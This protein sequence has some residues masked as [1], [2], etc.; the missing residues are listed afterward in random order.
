MSETFAPPTVDKD[1]LVALKGMLAEA[2][3]Q[4]AE[5]H[6]VFPGLEAARLYSEKI[7]ELLLHHINE[8]AKR[9]G[10]DDLRESVCLAAIGGFGRSELLLHSDLDFCFLTDRE[11][12]ERQVEFIKAFLYPLWDLR[13]DLG[14]CHHS[15]KEALSFLGTDLSKTTALLETRYMWGEK[16]LCEELNER[17]HAKLHKD[18][19]QWF[20]KAL[21]EEARAR[22]TAHGDTVFL[23]EPDLK[24]SRGALRDLHTLLWIAFAN[25]G[26]SSL[27]LLEDNGI[28][29]YS[30]KMR[31]L[32]AWSFLLDLRNSLHLAAN[33]RIDKLTIDRQIDAAKR[34]GMEVTNATLAEETLMRFYYNHA[35]VVD[36][37]CQRLL[38]A[39]M[40]RVSSDE[41][42]RPTAP[43]QQIDRHFLVRGKDIWVEQRD[44][45][46]VVQDP[47]W[48]LR[49]FHIAAHE[50]KNPTDETLRHVEEH[51]RVV[52]DVFRKSPMAR[53][54]FLSVL[55]E[56]GHIAETLR[57][58]N[59]CGLLSA[60]LPEF[61]AVHNLPRIDHYHQFTVDEHLIRSV[62]VAERLQND[63][64]P[65]GMEHVAHVAKS[66]LRLDLLHLAL[67]IHDVGKGEG[68]AHVIRGMHS[69]Q[70][71]A[72]RMDMRPAEQEV[73]RSLVAN[74]QKMS[75]MALRRDIEDPNLAKELAEA[76][77][78]P[79]MLNMLYVHSAC[80][81]RAVSNDSW[82]DWRGRLL[83]DLYE[84]TMLV[85]KGQHETQPRRQ[86][87]NDLRDRI[88]DEVLKLDASP[89][90]DK[91]TLENFITDMPERYLRSVSV[92]DIA[93]HC[94]M[95]TR[96][97]REHRI[98]CHVD[99]FDSAN[100]VQITFVS[101][102]APGLFSDICGALATRG[103]NILS[104]Q[105]YTAMS[106]EAV[107]IFQVKVPPKIAASIQE[108]LQ[109]ISDQL[110]KIMETGER[111]EW[112]TLVRK[113]IGERP[114]SEDRL[115]LRPPRVDINNDTSPTH[116]VVE[117]RAPDQPGLL[118]EITHVFGRHG[119]NI[120]LA[121]IATESYQIVDVFYVTDLETNK[122]QEPARIKALHSELMEVV[123]SR[124][125]PA[126]S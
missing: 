98:A 46:V 85:L 111:P 54:Y 67:L 118:S 25:H 53:W 49:L 95:S 87:R 82:N 109:R 59:R 22:H 88:W 89:Y 123:N 40:R 52:D 17:V 16:S 72:E 29:S 38:D 101:N 75:H 96:L 90:I 74:H 107:D 11:P 117:V 45:P 18:H 33:R 63:D 51:N 23:L 113:Q 42:H 91:P 10:G 73:L 68:R 104:A 97:N 76:V 5:R 120:D 57:A 30:E 64:P 103:I 26:A 3:E 60:Y 24:N 66:I 20:A 100:Y 119:V 80:D 6:R 116:T 44:L 31:L 114:V 70:R 50:G 77:G 79:E 27:D 62:G 43:P 99:D 8:T 84:R 122:L 34:M 55:Q 19:K 1:Y 108:V 102:D 41:E 115:S 4:A 125:R 110:T 69:A 78:R 94:L 13:F 93:R 126:D 112:T 81:L 86:P 32:A 37:V 21:V 83:A 92:T 36:R 61:A 9:F 124:L 7:E 12:T 39:Q 105:I 15:I 58:M 28:I 48:A 47:Y 71:I 14:N 35:N 2:R 56:P 106:G 65:A 121:F